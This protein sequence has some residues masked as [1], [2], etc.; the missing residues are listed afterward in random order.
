MN[1]EAPL[2]DWPMKSLAQIGRV[3]VAK[4]N[5]RAFPDETF[6]YY[7]IPAYQ[8]DASPDLSK[9]S[10]ILSHKLLIPARCVLFGKLNPRVQKVWNVRAGVERRRLASTEWLTLVP[11]PEVDQDYLYFLMY[12][13]WVMPIAQTLVSGSTPSRQRVNEKGFFE[14]RVPVPSLREQEKIADILR[15]IHRSI[16]VC[17]SAIAACFALR[18]EATHRLFT[19]GL[20]D[21]PMKDTEIGP[22][23]RSW[24]VGSLASLCQ[25]TD[26]VDVRRESDR[27]IEYVDVSSIDRDFN[28]IRSTSTVVLGS[29]PSRARKRIRTGDVI[30]ATVRPTL[31]RVATVPPRLDDQV[32]STAFCVLRRAPAVAVHDFIFYLVQRR[33]YIARLAAVER[34]ANYPAVTDRAVKEQ[35][36]S[37]PGLDEQKEIVELLGAIDLKIDLHRRKKVVLEQLFR[38]LLHDLMTGRIRADELERSDIE[39]DT[40][41]DAT[42]NGRE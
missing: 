22:I 10:E 27:K 25:D 11:V 36:V 29:A 28:R 5:P 2:P 16:S 6:E 26:L 1:T 23:P 13:D 39:T 32:C 21:E 15:L 40:D 42:P 7:S 20:R 3:E 8:N 9:G 4:L 14:I 19:Q 18:T 31:L 34:G 33:E 41:G 30:F 24:R 35:L 12:S 38:T 37:I 17:R